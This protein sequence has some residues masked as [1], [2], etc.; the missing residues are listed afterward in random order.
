[1][2]TPTPKLS[3]RDKGRIYEQTL[4]GEFHSWLAFWI[5]HNPGRGFVAER[6]VGPHGAPITV[7]AGPGDALI[8]ESLGLGLEAPATDDQIDRIE[9]VFRRAGSDEARI[10]LSPYADITL[11][12]R[13]AARGFELREF[14]NVYFRL[15]DRPPEAERPSGIDIRRIDSADASDVAET[16][17]LIA[18]GM[19]SLAPSETPPDA[20]RLIAEQIVGCHRVAAF[21][22]SID[23]VPAGGAC[24]G[25]W[26]GHPLA[27]RHLNLFS[28]ATL[29]AFRGRGVQRALMHA[30]LHYGFE[31]G[32]RSASLDCSPHA[33]TD[34]NAPRLG[35]ERLYTK[36]VLRKPMKTP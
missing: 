24:C 12:Q 32:A 18:Q 23:G 2:T 31:Q 10:E 13:L 5:D 22:A 19:K 21:V 36:A 30:R 9:D 7:A 17:A 33:A 14:L 25:V 34:R 6:L 4:A 26:E 8:N 35:F 15:L 27:P 1:M 11:P 29:P 3:A 28:G 20:D 16:A